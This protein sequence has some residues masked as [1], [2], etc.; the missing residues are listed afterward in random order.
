MKNFSYNI[1]GIFVLIAASLSANEID[2]IQLHSKSL[3]QLVLETKNNE[4][5]QG[6][7]LEVVNTGDLDND[8]EENDWLKIVTKPI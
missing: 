8:K 7:L 3:D 2:I 5:N 1:I 6:V 4:E